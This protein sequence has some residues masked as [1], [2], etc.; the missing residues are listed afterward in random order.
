MLPPSPPPLLAVRVERVALDLHGTLHRERRRGREDAM[1]V[2]VSAF[3]TAA[4]AGFFH[5]DEPLTY[6]AQTRLH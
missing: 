1:V 4:V 6:R 5:V 2:G 3:T